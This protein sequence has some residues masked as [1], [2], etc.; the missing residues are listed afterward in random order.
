MVTCLGHSTSETLSS[1]WLQRKAFRRLPVPGLDKPVTIAPCHHV[2][3][4]AGSA[5]RLARMLGSALAEAL[6]NT[7]EEPDEMAGTT[8]LLLLPRHLSDA[9]R[10]GLEDQ[11]RAWLGANV[12]VKV[13]IGGSGLA[14]QA[15]TDAYSMLE[16]NNRPRRLVVAS[17]DSGCQPE[18]LAREGALGRLH[19]AGN[20]E[21]YIAAESAACVVLEP[22]NSIFALPEG[23]F[24]LHRPSVR[25]VPPI[26]QTQMAPDSAMLLEVTSEALQ[27]SGMESPHIG[28]LVS[29]ADGSAWRSRWESDMQMRQNLSATDRWRPAELLGQ[30]GVCTGLLSWLLP[31]AAH[32]ARLT[33]VNNA[34]AWSISPDGTLAANVLERSP[35]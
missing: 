10:Q 9:A 8:V 29:D 19:T 1:W 2:D 6:D 33:R 34:L 15:L 24:A 16:G 27:R 35:H 12:R 31:M 32:Q 26:D 4:D 25:S 3:G 11:L 7:G 14:W 18:R 20:G 17:V 22:V 28:T 23:M 21:G 30:T 5:T 13:L